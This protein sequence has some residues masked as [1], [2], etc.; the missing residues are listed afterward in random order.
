MIIPVRCFTCG[1]VIA[2]KWR[3]YETRV[4]EASGDD[5]TPSDDEVAAA[6]SRVMTDLGITRICCR[7][8][9]LTTVDLMDSI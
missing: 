6:K 2:D 1:K 3:A 8:H 9:F 7:R 4:A 5:T